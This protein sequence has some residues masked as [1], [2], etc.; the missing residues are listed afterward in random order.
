MLRPFTDGEL[1]ERLFLSEKDG[2]E[3]ALLAEPPRLEIMGEEI[4]LSG[5]EHSLL[6]LLLSGEQISYGDLMRAAWTDGGA[7]ANLL[8]VTVSHLRKKLAPFGIR[9]D[10]TRGAYQIKR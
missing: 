9:I 7:D 3:P 1:L 2:R 8:R 4:A 10:S 5:I 6:A